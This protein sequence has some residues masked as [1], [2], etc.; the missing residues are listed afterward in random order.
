MSRF[1]R[2]FAAGALALLGLADSARA[3]IRW[4]FPDP[5][6]P[7]AADTLHVHN[8]FMTIAGTI[9][10]LVFLL[11]MYS[12][13]VHRKSKG[14][15]AATFTAPRTGKQIA[16]TLLPFAGLLYIDYV[17]FGIP[18]YHAVLSYEDSKTNAEMVVKVTGSQWKWLYEY[19]AEDI[20]FVSLLTTPKE[21]IHNQAPKGE[22]YLLEVDNPL[23]LPVGKK[24][25]FIT[26]ST[27]VIHSWWVPAF[28]VK[29]DA[30]PGFL[31]EFWAT[32]EKPGVYRG[33]CAELCGKD[34]GFM[35]VV[36]QAV[37][38]GD[39]DKWVAE[40]KAAVIAAAASADKEWT[41][42]EL[43]SKGKEVYEKVCAAC[44]Q[45]NG[46]GLPPAF[47]ALAGSA[48][49]KGPFVDKD[50]RLV[51]DGHLDRVL[52]GKAGTAMQAFRESLS[53]AEVAAV[54][55]FERNSFGNAVGDFVQPSVVKKLR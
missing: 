11:I 26:T 33:Q 8:L 12:V 27:D 1:R 14:Y 17:V 2:A 16:L 3:E 36:V 53:D 29:R 54:V 38:Q 39:F 49:V 18:A 30:V 10:V 44:H 19:P 5:A 34:H 25:R 6:T 31:R 37:S 50:G 43:M 40:K 23:V 7:L 46:Q 15:K 22:N 24:I 42:D 48:M 13:V 21:Q 51:K 45:A 9:F 4:T 55:T 47:P 52:N 20:K 32:I 28:G 35:P 41:K